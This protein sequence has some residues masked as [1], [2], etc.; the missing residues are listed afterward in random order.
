M[1]KTEYKIYWTLSN[2]IFS[3]T[4]TDLTV[5]L[6]VTE[7]LRTRRR[8]GED[9]SFVTMVSENVDH[10]GETGVNS[11]KN[12]ELP[13]GGKYTWVKRRPPTTT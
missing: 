2:E 5:A 13:D 1:K 3:V 7:T 10:I 11:V 8:S 9:I 6:G 12:G 4:E